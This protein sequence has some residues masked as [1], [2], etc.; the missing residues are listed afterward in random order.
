MREG[1]PSQGSLVVHKGGRV[2]CPT[3]PRSMGDLLAG[4]QRGR[5]RIWCPSD[6]VM[7]LQDVHDDET[8]HEFVIFTD[9]SATMTEK[10]PREAACAGW[11]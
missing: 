11:R 9:G 2:E 5:E 4:I 7:T 8:A 6:E 1:A 3:A 10:W